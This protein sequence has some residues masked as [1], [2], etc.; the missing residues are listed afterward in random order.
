MRGEAGMYV[1]SSL[2]VRASAFEPTKIQSIFDLR[3]QLGE[4]LRNFRETQ[5]SK[6]ENEHFFRGAMPRDRGLADMSQG[7]LK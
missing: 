3:A 6:V 1:V 2:Y 5:G 4:E 7:S